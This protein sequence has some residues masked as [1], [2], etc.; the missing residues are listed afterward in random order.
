VRPALLAARRNPADNP[1]NVPGAPHTAYNVKDKE[2]HR[3]AIVNSHQ[4]RKISPSKVRAAAAAAS[5]LAPANVSDRLLMV[6]DHKLSMA[7]PADKYRKWLGSLC[8]Q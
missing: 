4:A 7:S 1:H 3:Q 5:R 6:P 2:V 8:K